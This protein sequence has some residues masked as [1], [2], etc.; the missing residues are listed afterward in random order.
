MRLPRY[1][2][3]CTLLLLVLG[4]SG[5]QVSQD[6]DLKAD[7]SRLQTFA[8]KSNSQV[9]TG[10]VRVDNPLLDARIR[11]AVERTLTAKGFRKV[12]IGD[13]DFTVSYV[14]Q[15][16]R[17]IASDSVRTNIGFGSG[18]G[19]RVGG[20]SVSSSGGV[21]ETDEGMLIIDLTGHGGSHLLWRGTG[22]RLISG[23]S[24]P[25]QITAEVHETVEEILAQFPPQPN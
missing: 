18:S 3:L 2:C 4:C 23:R 9:N 19:G 16:R 1:H 13:A 21:R 14:F 7:F 11:A 12:P 10:D 8:W 17:K 24:N 22:I 20:V 15:I 5:I 25:N 6:Y